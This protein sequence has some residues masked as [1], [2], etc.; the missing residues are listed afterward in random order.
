MCSKRAMIEL[1]SVNLYELGEYVYEKIQ[2]DV[3]DGKDVLDQNS[4]LYLMLILQN[5]CKVL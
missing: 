5:L 4:T 1:D 3:N 2:T